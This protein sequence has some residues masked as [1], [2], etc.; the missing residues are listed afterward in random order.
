MNWGKYFLPISTSTLAII[1]EKQETKGKFLMN[2]T[3]VPRKDLCVHLIIKSSGGKGSSVTIQV[4]GHRC[5]L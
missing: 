1:L 5:L 3:A 4:G 2:E